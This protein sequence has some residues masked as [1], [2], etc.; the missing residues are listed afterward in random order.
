MCPPCDNEM[1]SEAIV[2]HLC[3]SEFGKEGSWGHEG[4]SRGDTGQCGSRGG[5]SCRCVSP[6]ALSR[7]AGGV[8]GVS[9]SPA[10]SCGPSPGRD[11]SRCQCR[12]RDDGTGRVRDVSGSRSPARLGQGALAAEPALPLRPGCG[13]AERPSRPARG[14]QLRAESQMV[15]GCA[16][17]TEPRWQSMVFGELGGF[18]T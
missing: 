4:A 11:A 1:K 14:H 9:A 7:A 16:L 13:G 15:W 17:G 8:A 3:A 12:L 5:G 2:E 6:P 10:G 18:V